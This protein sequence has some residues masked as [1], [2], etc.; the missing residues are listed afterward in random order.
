MNKDQ[1]LVHVTQNL[2]NL[3]DQIK[4][5]SDVALGV[6]E[7]QKNPVDPVNSEDDDIPGLSPYNGE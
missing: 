7:A 4:L 5:V 2:E 3:A 6:K 1:K